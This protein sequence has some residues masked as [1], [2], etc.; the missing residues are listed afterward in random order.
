MSSLSSSER[1]R[2]EKLHEAPSHADINAETSGE[3]SDIEHQLPPR[4]GNNADEPK[5]V[6]KYTRKMKDKLTSS[7]HH[8]RESFRQ[9]RAREEQ[10]AYER[11]RVIR[12]AMV[13]AIQTGQPQYL[14]KNKEGKGVYIDPPSNRGGAYSGGY[15]GSLGY[16]GTG[17]G[18]GGPPM[19]GGVGNGVMMRPGIGYGGRPG[20]G[21]RPGYGYGGGMGL[22]LM[23]GLV[24]GAMLGGA[25]F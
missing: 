7:T 24:G 10:A 5:G 25:L 4:Q 18:W 19:V 1:A 9:Q 22:P 2:I 13:K 6:K 17:Y 21:R 12:A 8:E 16:G 11:H 3:D 14:G 23:G 20:Y 15:P